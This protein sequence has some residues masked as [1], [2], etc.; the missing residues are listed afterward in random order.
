MLRA[1][2]LTSA[3]RPARCLADADLRRGRS[4][5]DQGAELGAGR[6]E[7]EALLI[8][9]RVVAADRDDEQVVRPEA[10]VDPR[11]GGRAAAGEEGLIFGAEARKARGG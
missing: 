6:R 9:A 3:V 8:G 7:P 10:A 2:A 5:G 1:P 4:A 11:E